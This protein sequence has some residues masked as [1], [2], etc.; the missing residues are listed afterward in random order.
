M[1]PY[2]SICGYHGNQENTNFIFHIN[3]QMIKMLLFIIC[4]R[5]ALYQVVLNEGEDH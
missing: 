5:C 3:F 2:V 4:G 1:T